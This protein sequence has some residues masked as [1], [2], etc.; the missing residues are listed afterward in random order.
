MIRFAKDSDVPA[1]MTFID[2]YWRKNHI[3]SRDKE[4]FEFQHKWGNEIS[5]VILLRHIKIGKIGVEEEV[6][7]NGRSMLQFTH[8]G[9]NLV[10]DIFGRIRKLAG[11]DRKL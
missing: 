8:E 5:F 2:K 7:D 4:L 10:R 3:M 6:G 11:M 1:I 9:M